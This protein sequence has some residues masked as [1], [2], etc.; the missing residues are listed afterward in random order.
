MEP[1][2]YGGGGIG[3]GDQIS[4][5]DPPPPVVKGSMAVTSK[6][7][8]GK[9]DAASSSSSSSSSSLYHSRQRGVRLRLRRRAWPANRGGGVSDDGDSVQDLGLPLGMSFA[10]VVAQVLNGMTISGER[11]PVDHLCK[12]CTSAVKESVVNIYGNR[13]NC[14]VRSFEKSFGSTLR[15]LHVINETSTSEQGYTSRPSFLYS[16]RGAAENL[17]S[18]DLRSGIEE[19]QENQ[20]LDSMNN[21]LILH[22]QNSRQLAHICH[23]ISSPEFN[24]H[25]ISTY[26][27]SVEEQSRSNDLKEV[28]IGLTMKRLQLK[29]S[30]LALSSYTHVLEKIKISMG[31]AKASFKEEKLRNQML[32]S[33]HAELLKRFIDLLVTGLIIMLGCFAYGT[34]VY[35]YQRITEVASACK[36]TSKESRSWWMPKSAASFSSGW[37][38]LRCH[39]IVLTRMFFGILMILA[40]VWLILQRS[41]VS[42]PSMPVTFNVVL[43]GVACGF[44]GKLCVDALGGHGYWWLLFWEGLCLL[45]FLGNIFPSS[46]YHILCGPI[47]LSQ[48]TKVPKLPYWL[49]RY[50]FYSILLLVL[51]VSAG[52]LPFASI[53]DWKEH[54]AGKIILA[55]VR[56]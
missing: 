34:S 18:L 24:Q 42:G 49:R 8:R 6:A 22:G 38:F 37:L 36:A 5:A 23:N 39:V 7:K 26:E 56:T 48:G 27:R 3:G 31:V 20:S 14:F 9:K 13:Y 25:I 16:S 54:F 15:T 1:L 45:H 51:P 11:L 50:T 47:S 43:L 35:S 21:Q 52:L 19:F 17:D 30:Q 29:E 10:A 2:K 41:L 28:E 44:S 33:R 55:P 32:D 53:R 4:A 40:I 46:F 12:I